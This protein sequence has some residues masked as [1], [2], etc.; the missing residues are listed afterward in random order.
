LSPMQWSRSGGARYS[1][2][3]PAER[4]L[5]GIGGSDRRCAPVPIRA[6]T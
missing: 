4:L 3:P 2:P 6:L 5:R 1:V